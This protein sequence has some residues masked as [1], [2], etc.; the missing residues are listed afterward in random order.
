MYHGQIGEGLQRHTLQQFPLKDSV[1]RVLINTIA[2][3]MGVEI[4]DVTTVLHWGKSQSMLSYWQ[5]VGRGGRDGADS[6]AIL[7]PKS[8]TGDDKELFDKLKKDKSACI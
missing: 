8:T 4:P 5:E 1:I 3:G 6:R 7:F 2:F